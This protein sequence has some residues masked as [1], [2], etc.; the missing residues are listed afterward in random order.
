MDG[1]VRKG[2][3][4]GEWGCND[5]THVGGLGLALG[6]DGPSALAQTLESEA[7]FNALLGLFVRALFCW[8]LFGFAYTFWPS[9]NRHFACC[10]KVMHLSVS[11]PPVPSHPR[12][13]SITCNSV[14]PYV[15]YPV[16]RVH[17]FKPLRS[18]P[19]KIFLLLQK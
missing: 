17:V 7:D 18:A 10:K 15:L 13:S 3:G 1:R 5:G 4:R 19:L 8:P 12:P 9:S 16:T 6:L 2:R 11:S 14:P